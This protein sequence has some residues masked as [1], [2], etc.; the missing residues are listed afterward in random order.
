MAYKN[1]KQD[2]KLVREFHIL[3]GV[4]Y[5][6]GQVPSMMIDV[7]AKKDAWSGGKD[8]ATTTSNSSSSTISKAD[9]VSH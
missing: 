7:V 8:K 5:K 6:D 1:Q 2:V 9:S 3:K 4:L